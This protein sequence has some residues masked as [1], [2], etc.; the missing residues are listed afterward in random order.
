MALSLSFNICTK[1]GCKSLVFTETTGV[2][3]IVNTTGYGDPNPLTTEFSS[4]TLVLTFNDI[5]YTFDLTSS[6]FPTSDDNVVFEILPSDIG[7]TDV[8]T[9]GIY[10]FKYTITG[11]GG[12]YFQTGVNATY[13]N[14]SC[15]VSQMLCD[16][17]VDCDCSK[18]KL[19]KY[20]KASILL[21]QLEC[22]GN[23][24]NV[25]SF[26]NALDVINKLCKNSGCNCN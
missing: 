3:S 23:S 25:V 15:C 10:Y 9:D 14:A 4:A 8:I 13:C 17:D 21:K 6:N 18:S 16:I 24:D 20:I 2:Y 11:T 12:T 7:Q 19:D 26:N 22:A 1:S 5:D